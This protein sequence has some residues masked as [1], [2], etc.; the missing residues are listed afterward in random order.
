MKEAK[1]FLERLKGAKG[2]EGDKVSDG[3]T[4]AREESQERERERTTALVKLR[5]AL[6]E[7]ERVFGPAVWLSVVLDLT[8][9]VKWSEK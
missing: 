2:S 3:I 5:E 8:Y 6:E 1:P 7:A 4:H 9:K